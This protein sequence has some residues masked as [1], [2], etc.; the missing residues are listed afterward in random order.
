M[1]AV[2]VGVRS[3]PPVIVSV[4]F[5]QT[6]HVWDLEEGRVGALRE[7]PNKATSVAFTDDRLVIGTSAELLRVDL[8]AERPGPLELTDDR[9]R[10][11]RAA[12]AGDGRNLYARPG[13]AGVLDPDG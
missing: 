5:D 8:L 7:L 1:V 9:A 10:L 13:R 6:V 3:G 11:T 4:G 12:E 2:A